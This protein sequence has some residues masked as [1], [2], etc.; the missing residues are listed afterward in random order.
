V[1]IVVMVI[2]VV[3][4]LGGLIVCLTHDVRLYA[5][6]PWGILGMFL[7]LFAIIIGLVFE[8]I[9]NLLPK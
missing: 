4:S 3:I 5:R 6:I 2:G 9:I 7:G 1:N 8:D